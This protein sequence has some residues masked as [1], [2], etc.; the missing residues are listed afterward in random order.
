MILFGIFDF[1]SFDFH[2]CRTNV[3]F[4]F[5]IRYV[6]CSTGNDEGLKPRKL[7]EILYLMEAPLWL[8]VKMT[9]ENSE[10]RKKPNWFVWTSDLCEGN[11]WFGSCVGLPYQFASFVVVFVP[12]H[13]SY[14]NT[15]QY[16]CSPRITALINFVCECWLWAYLYIDLCTEESVQ[17][18]SHQRED[19]STV[20]RRSSFLRLSSLIHF[21]Y[22]KFSF[23]FYFCA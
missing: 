10:T 23:Q 8:H 17:F 20:E 5:V 7:N 16:I 4:G 14:R 19:T 11:W 13:K 15:G 12:N 6:V 21:S 9:S 18:Q 1:Y 22:L 3:L 2:L